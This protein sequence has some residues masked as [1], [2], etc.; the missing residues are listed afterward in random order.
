MVWWWF[1]WNM[2]KNSI[3]GWNNFWRVTALTVNIKSYWIKIYDKDMVYKSDIDYNKLMS[4]ISFT[5][6]MNWG[7]GELI[8]QLNENFD[9]SNY[10]LWEYIKIYSYD[11]YNAWTLIYTWYITK[12]NRV[13]NTN[14][15]TIEL[16][17]LWLAS[18]LTKYRL[19]NRHYW[20]SWTFN[21]TD[22]WTAQQIDAY[23]QLFNSDFWVDIIT[24]DF[25]TTPRT[26]LWIHYPAIALNVSY[27][28]IDMYTLITNIVWLIWYYWYLWA[29]WK[30]IFMPLPT[31]ITHYFTNQK[32]VEN[33]IV[34][35]NMEWIINDVT[36]NRYWW[37]E[38]TYT[39]ATS[40]SLYWLK[41]AYIDMS[42]S[43]VNEATQ[44]L[45]WAAFLNDFKDYKKETNIVVNNKYNI[46]SIIPGQAI[47]LRNFEY[48]FSSSMMTVLQTRYSKN[49]I[50]ITI[51][52]T[53]LFTDMVVGA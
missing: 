52:K 46:E 14:S 2:W 38:K 12:I 45:Y 8:L 29:D 30:M 6:N 4:E 20:Y 1:A 18:L 15:Q 31:T 43:I 23:C 32:D 13:Q 44:D 7:Q 11:Y 33:I 50:S 51:N 3:D 36:I 25:S 28:A 35:D 22:I 5:N 9:T 41:S 47:S 40:K 42:W 10:T 34:Q 53:T 39:D 16:V 48:S 24:H 49:N 19:D 17:L 37:V 21:T 27:W 26:T